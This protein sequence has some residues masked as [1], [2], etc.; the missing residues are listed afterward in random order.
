MSHTRIQHLYHYPIKG[1]SPAPLSEISLVSHQHMPYDRAFAVARE[2]GDMTTPSET[3]HPKKAFYQLASYPKIAQLSVT[4]DIE[5]SEITFYRHDRKVLTFNPFTPI[6]ATMV[7]QFLAAFLAEEGE[8]IRPRFITSG[9]NIAF[10]DKN[11]PYISLVNLNSI[12]DLQRL[13]D[14]EIDPLRFRANIYLQ[15]MPAWAENDLIGKIIRFGK[16]EMRIIERIDRCRAT[17]VNLH[18]AQRDLNVPKLLRK[19]FGH[20][21]MG[22]FAEVLTS[23]L[24]KPDLPLEIVSA[25]A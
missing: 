20:I 24:L 15:D 19:G 13:S 23:G 1:F 17:E 8:I 7:E 5:N 3:W 12:K 2:I 22:I 11:H 18:T 6:G 4:H 16:V 14:I 25:P 9:D 10:T 21:D